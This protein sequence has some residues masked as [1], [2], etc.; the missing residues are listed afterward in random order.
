MEN[1]KKVNYKFREPELE[2]FSPIHLTKEAHGLIKD[3]KKIQ[4]KTMARILDNLI[5]EKYGLKIKIKK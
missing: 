5:K 1:K 4:G 2:Q 3:Q